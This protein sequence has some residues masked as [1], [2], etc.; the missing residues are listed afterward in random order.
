MKLKQ[1]YLD[2]LSLLEEVYD[3]NESVSIIRLLFDELELNYLKIFSEPA[4]VISEDKYIRLQSLREK[5]L[6]KIPLQYVLGY[7]WFYDRKFN[8]GSG[9]LIPRSETEE[10]VYKLIEDGISFEKVLDIGTGSGCLAV[11]I[12]AEFPGSGVWAMDKYPSALQLAKQNALL[13]RTHIHFIQDDIL[14]PFYK[15]YPGHFDLIVSNPPYVRE[16]EKIFMHDNVLKNEPLEA[17]FVKDSDPLVFYRAISD[18]CLKMLIPGG[19]LFMEINEA[20]GEET[21][22]LFRNEHFMETTIVK[23]IHNKD[24]FIKTTRNEH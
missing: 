19:L 5:L 16:S 20:L 11:S 2:T 21:A 15:K 7:A 9:C 14:N 4:S 23:D 17:L 24:R 6:K 10:I 8:V 12:K 18:F 13:N 22:A 1:A 3:K